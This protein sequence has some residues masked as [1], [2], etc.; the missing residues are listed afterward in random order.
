MREKNLNFDRQ[1]IF[2]F[3]Q[4]KKYVKI[5]KISKSILKAFANDKEIYKII[6]FSGTVVLGKII[7]LD[8]GKTGIFFG[9]SLFIILII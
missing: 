8:S 1:K 9:K 4:D 6:I 3:F 7:K 2:K 5:T